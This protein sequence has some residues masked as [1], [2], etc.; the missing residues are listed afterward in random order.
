MHDILISK[1][2]QYCV[3]CELGMYQDKQKAIIPSKVMIMDIKNNKHRVLNRFVVAAHACFDPGNPYIVY[4]S[5]HNFEFMH[6]NMITP[7]R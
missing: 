3:T 4:F 6:S 5:N 2:R 7:K 1:T